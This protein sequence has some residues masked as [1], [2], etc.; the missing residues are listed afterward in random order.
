VRHALAARDPER[1]AALIERHVAEILARN[2]R[3]T[4]ERWLAT[5]P[6]EIV[7]SRPRQCLARAYRAM[8]GGQLEEFA[9]L[10]D[11]A[12]R[13]QAAGRG[14][15]AQDVAPPAETGWAAAFLADVP[16]TVAVLRAALARLRGDADRPRELALGRTRLVDVYGYV[17]L[18]L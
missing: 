4:V 1:A 13:A 18:D 6:G 10:L 9:R 12:E 2:E 11:D 14:P 16:A 3:A 8:V 7:R 17:L 5:L 15:D